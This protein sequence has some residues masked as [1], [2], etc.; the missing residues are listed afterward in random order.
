MDPKQ[1]ETIRQRATGQTFV[2]L[3]GLCVEA[4]RVESWNHSGPVRVTLRGVWLEKLYEILAATGA[5][6]IERIEPKEETPDE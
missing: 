5:G 1:V 4:V 3:E 2:D 6:K